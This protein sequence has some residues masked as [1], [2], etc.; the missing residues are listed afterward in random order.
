MGDDLMKTVKNRIWIF[1]I[2]L[3]AAFLPKP[4]DAQEPVSPKA[5]YVLAQT[6]RQWQAERKNFVLVDVREPGEYAAGHIEGAV[7]I[8][9]A[10]LEGRAGEIKR[11]GTDYVFYCIHSSWRA[12]YSANLLMD[13]GY[14]NVYVLEGGISAWNA[15]GQVIMASGETPAPGVIVPYPVE[16]PKVLKHPVDQTHDGTL[17]LTPE[18]L[19]Y[20]DGEDGRPAYVAV[21]GI[22]YD[23]TR[24]R[25]WRGG[26]HDP[27]H[28][29]VL[30]GRD[31]TRKI[32]D[33]P[34]GTK[35]LKNYP[36]VG[37]LIP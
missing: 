21:D 2:I 28:G 6:V 31:L 3:S 17:D 34:H 23:L 19:S 9:Y 37:K 26:A 30:A 18:E 29:E 22:I 25:L 24:S 5:P 12:P 11:E 14:R 20:Y 33:S 7:N 8:P 15:G 13:L 27:A 1:T 16:T 10:R 32:K 4:T 36:V 35:H